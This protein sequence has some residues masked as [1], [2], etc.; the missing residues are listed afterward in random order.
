MKNYNRKIVFLKLLK[1]MYD[2]KL[3]ES[4]ISKAYDIKIKDLYICTLI[5]DTSS[6]GSVKK[7]NKGVWYRGTGK[8]QL[9][10]GDI[11]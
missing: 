11:L 2:E 3:S 1:V 10:N 8:G 9:A 6:D 7:C 4:E 5:L